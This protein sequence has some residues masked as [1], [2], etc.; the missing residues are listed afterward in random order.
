MIDLLRYQKFALLWTAV[1]ALAMLL[2]IPSLA[3]NYITP[4]QH[5]LDKLVHIFLYGTMAFLWAYGFY[6]QRVYNALRVR[7]FRLAAAITIIYSL[8]LEIAQQW[9]PARSFEWT[10]LVANIFGT[11]FAYLIFRTLTQPLKTTP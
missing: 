4:A 11:V 3:Q 10:D 8:V 6:R 1:V 7:A 9:V 2:P 5:L